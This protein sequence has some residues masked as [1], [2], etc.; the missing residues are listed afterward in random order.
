LGIDRAIVAMS[1]P[2]STILSRAAMFGGSGAAK[3]AI[4]EMSAG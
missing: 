1:S 2:A 4:G 3:P